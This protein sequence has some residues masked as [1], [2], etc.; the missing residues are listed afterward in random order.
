MVLNISE[1]SIQS[2]VIH[3]I[4]HLLLESAQLWKSRK[5]CFHIC[6]CWKKPVEY[7]KF[8]NLK[9]CLVWVLA[10]SSFPNSF[11]YGHKFI[12][13]GKFIIIVFPMHKPIFSQ[14][15]RSDNASAKSNGKQEYLL[16]GFQGVSAHRFFVNLE[17]WVVA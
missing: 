17:R 14:T 12:V 1:L 16:Q 2:K 15:I 6:V 3:L 13:Y 11:P 10:L 9:L 4:S 7:N 5:A 8:R